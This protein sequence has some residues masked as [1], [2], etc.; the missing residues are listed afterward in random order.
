MIDKININPVFVYD[1]D[2]RFCRMW[3]DYSKELTGNKIDYVPFQSLDWQRTPRGQEVAENFPNISREEFAKAVQ[4]IMPDGGVYGGAH[5]TLKALACVPRRGW[6]LWLYENFF[7]FKILFDLGYRFVASHRNAFYYLTRW[8]HGKEIKP[9]AFVSVRWLFLRTLGVIYLIAFFSFGIQAAGLIGSQ[10]ILPMDNLFKVVGD[11]FGVAGYWFLPSVFWLNAS[12]IFLSIVSIFGI[13]ASFFL[14]F[15]FWVRWSLVALFVLYLSLVSAGQVFM[16]FQWDVL[17]LETGFLAIL[18]SF[19]TGVVWAFRVLLFKF[20]FLSGAAKLLSGDSTWRDLTALTY[21]YETQPLPT[22]LAWFVHQLPVW[23]HQLSVVVMFT[24][25]LGISFLLFGPRRL[26]FVAALSIIFLEVLI[27]LTGNYNFFNL[28]TIALCIL[29]L[30]DRALGRILP[31]NLLRWIGSRHI[32]SSRIIRFATQTLVTLIIFVSIFQVVGMLSGNLAQPAR[33]LHE[34]VAPL[35]IVNTYGLFANMT[36]RRPEIIIEGSNDGEIWHAYEFKYK[37]GRLEKAPVW[38]APHQPRLD[39]QM[40]FAALGS[41]QNN[42]W[43]VNFMQRLLEGSPPALELIKYNPF[44]LAPPRQVRAV[45]YEYHFTDFVT[46]RETDTWWRRELKG[47][48]FPSVSL[49]EE[50]T[51]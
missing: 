35:R 20:V 43:F 17:L 44:P 40:W 51:L 38:A 30:D 32:I 28:L 15:G 1:G 47:L 9:G 46:R 50:Q 33:F 18:L 11:R 21:H 37:P 24:V 41:Y 27:A 3:I 4:L 45:L 22:S 36:T 48:Y 12:D 31:R 7:G 29:V 2:C 23:F 19:W 8:L 25:Q 42:P 5:A 39:W 26:R 10:G 13:V 14:I 16:A 34:L 49:R 6:L